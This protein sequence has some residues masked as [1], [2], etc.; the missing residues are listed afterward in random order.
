MEVISC[1]YL[2]Y[3]MTEHLRNSIKLTFDYYE[4]LYSSADSTVLD[5]SYFSRF[6]SETHSLP[7]MYLY[8]VHIGVGIAISAS[9]SR[10][11]NPL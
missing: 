1:A 10:A 3:T 11:L 7:S 2:L 5:V 9:A 6:L 4:F 8:F